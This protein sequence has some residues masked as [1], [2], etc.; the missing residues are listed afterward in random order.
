MSPI[1]ER[2]NK[3]TKGPFHTVQQHACRVEGGRRSPPSAEEVRSAGQSDKQ[4]RVTRCATAELEVGT[5]HRAQERFL[6]EVI[7]DLTPDRPAG[8]SR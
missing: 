8:V 3:R 7:S 6:K 5:D 4:R 2:N 1:R